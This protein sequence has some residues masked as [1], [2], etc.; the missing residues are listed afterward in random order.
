MCLQAYGIDA[1]ALAGELS[2]TCGA[3]AGVQEMETK[4]GVT[5]REIMVQGL[6]DRRVS[7]HLQVQYGLP[8]NAIDNRADGKAGMHQKKVKQWYKQ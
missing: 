5:K 7:E 4:A 1:A 3:N 6:W 8:A 2:V